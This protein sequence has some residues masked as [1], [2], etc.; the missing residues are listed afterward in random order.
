M[1][2]IVNER[3]KIENEKGK[4]SVIDLER[5]ET[6]IVIE[7]GI[8]AIQEIEEGVVHHVLVANHALPGST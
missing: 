1:I 6:E 4:E 5:I 8:T 7:T 2:V 3:E